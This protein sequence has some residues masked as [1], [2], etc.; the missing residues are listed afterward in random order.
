MNQISRMNEYQ[1]II[2]WVLNHQINRDFN[3][4]RTAHSF[5]VVT[6][7]DKKVTLDFKS[8]LAFQLGVKEL[9]PGI[10]YLCNFNNNYFKHFTIRYNFTIQH[11]YTLNFKNI[12]FAP[13][14][15]KNRRLS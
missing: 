7:C 12:N 1:T 9:K 10:K 14:N 2:F 8:F 15:N 4:C 3:H 13:K 11:K 5:S 6:K